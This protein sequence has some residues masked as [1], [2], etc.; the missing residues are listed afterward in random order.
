MFLVHYIVYICGNE[1][2]GWVLQTIRGGI[3]AGMHMFVRLFECMIVG[4]D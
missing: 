2:G 1:F 4:V 3:P